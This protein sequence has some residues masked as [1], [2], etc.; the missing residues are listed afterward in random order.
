V[1]S[2]RILFVLRH[3]GYV[4]NFE[5]VVD[6]LAQEGH[7]VHLAFELP[8][9]SVE[10]AE[11]LA[12]RHAGVTWGR[13]PKR[14]DAWEPLTRDLR[15][16]MDALRY[17]SALYRDAPKLTA[18]GL[19]HAPATLRRLTAPKAM[20][21]P[22]VLGALHRVLRRLDATIPPDPG[23]EAFLGHQS[24]DLLLVTPLVDGPS[25]ED[26]VR[27]ARRR[28]VPSAL[29]VASWD[30][31]TNKGLIKVPLE[32]IF[33]W[34]EPQRREAIDLHGVS[35]DRVTATGA[36]SYDHWFAWRTSSNRAAFCEQVGLP[37]DRPYIL[38]LCSS[39]FIAPTEPA[40][41]RRWL[42]EL[43]A[44]PGPLRDCG[45]LVRPHPA[46]G[47]WWSEV[48]LDDLGPVA[49]WPPTGADPRSASAKADYFDSM[50]HC[51]AAVGVNTSAIVE[52]SIIGRPAF[53]VLAPEF[54]DTQQGTI[55]F[56]HLTSA[57]GGALTTATDFAE[58][59]AH[60]TVAVSA[61]EGLG[62]RHE[63]FLREFV[64][65]AGLERPAAPG[66]VEALECLAAQT[67][68]PFPA[69]ERADALLRWGLQRLAT[70]ARTRRKPRKP[71]KRQ[72][73]RR[74]LRRTPAAKLVRRQHR[75]VRRLARQ[76]G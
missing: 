50:Y 33:V 67:P 45:V 56:A 76:G 42:T 28:G 37:A 4:R 34:N 3:S 22:R 49:V 16:A 47:G 75:R 62:Q 54:A 21:R 32:H 38:Y 25:Q 73:M 70:R 52:L 12:A 66:T 31:L 61:G 40:F 48:D 57:G 30:N 46:S 72:S 35:P 29:C 69:P 8:R 11:A 14:A 41:V 9:E 17:R 24:P 10:V 7:R 5:A 36:H 64:R 53:T 74:R 60:L 18:R 58:H 13:A 15:Y 1:S 6:R 65:P 59:R 27:A 19:R 71:A 20:R 44:G 68:L 2:L 23:I 26:F 39:K 43:R 51:A 63:G 55:H